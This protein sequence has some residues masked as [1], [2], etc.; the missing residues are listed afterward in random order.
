[1]LPGGHCPSAQPPPD[2]VWH[3]LPVTTQSQNAPDVPPVVWIAW[4]ENPLGQMPPQVGNAELAQPTPGSVV[5]VVVG[6]A[7]VVVMQAHWALPPATNVLQICPA[8]QRP[9]LPH[10]PGNGPQ[11]ESGGTQKQL[12]TLTSPE[13]WIA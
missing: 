3:V 6:A 9:R 4:H 10:G 5:L 1:M 7:V 12:W 2:G 11:V 8:G 13:T